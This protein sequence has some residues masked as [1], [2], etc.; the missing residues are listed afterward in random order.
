MKKSEKL[1]TILGDVDEKFVPEIDIR[2]KK[3]SKLPWLTVSGG[4]CAAAII[5]FLVIHTLESR[6]PVAD[7]PSNS[8]ASTSTPSDTATPPAREELTF[9][10]ILENYRIFPEYSLEAASDNLTAIP[11]RILT[12]GMGFEGYLA[13]DISQLDN[14]NPWS[15]ELEL[16]A[17]P[18]FKNLAFSDQYIPSYL[19]E[20]QMSKMVEN[21]AFCLGVTIDSK[22]TGYISGVLHSYTAICSGENLG[23]EEVLIDISGRGDISITFESGISLPEEYRFTRHTTGNEDALE[24]LSY[25]A[26]QYQS[27]LQY[28]H[29]VSDTFADRAYSGTETRTFEVF[30]SSDDVVENLLNYHFRRANFA[31][32]GNGDLWIIR[33]SDP[34]CAAECIGSYP[35]ITAET[36]QALL[37]EGEFITNVPTA[38]LENGTISADAIKKTELIYRCENIDAYYQP[39]YRFYVKLPSGGY[40]DGSLADGLKEYGAF[41]VPAVSG[42]YLTDFTV[43]DGAFN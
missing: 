34:L 8:S 12:E 38:Y 14:A 20:E 25:F 15:P 33:L 43:W 18:V 7:S 35:I 5:G 23:V 26:G 41:Y 36:A 13:Y 22:E 6:P 4:I 3:N 30:E 28:E 31:P 17:L 16:E 24:I 9:G 42:E 32:D 10:E 29:P 37:L 11:S 40:A 39:Y 2:K 21:A 1:L 19:T 27:L